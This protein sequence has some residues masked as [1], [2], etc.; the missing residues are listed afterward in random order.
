MSFNTLATA[1]LTLLL[2]APTSNAA[3]KSPPDP[4]RTIMVYMAKGFPDTRLEGTEFSLPN[5]WY[6]ISSSKPGNKAIGTLLDSLGV[7]AKSDKPDA[8]A[9]PP[10]APGLFD[11]DLRAFVPSINPS[12]HTDE[13]TAT[14]YFV[15]TPAASYFFKSSTD[16]SVSCEFKAELFDGGKSTWEARYVIERDET[17]STKDPDVAAKLQQHFQKSFQL[18]TGMF[19]LHRTKGDT[20]FNRM[21]L[22]VGK[23]TSVKQVAPL[24]LPDR[25]VYLD[26]DGMVDE[27]VSHFGAGK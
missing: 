18:L 2:L 23:Q 17:F 10:Q 19:A 27:D 5:S 14:K 11:T 24:L 8:H 16:F 20:L 25:I 9:K 15:V 7:P 4:D 22:K 6:G 1:L 21:E 3:P 13:P 12:F 26:D